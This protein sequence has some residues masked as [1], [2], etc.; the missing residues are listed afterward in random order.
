MN[1]DDTASKEKL[2]NMLPEHLQERLKTDRDFSDKFERI[3]AQ[4]E[5]HEIS[6]DTANRRLKDEI[7]NAD[8][9]VYYLT[10]EIIVVQ[11]IAFK[12]LINLVDDLEAWLARIPPKTDYG[13][14]TYRQAITYFIDARKNVEFKR[15]VMVREKLNDGSLYLTLLLLDQNNKL[16]K[17]GKHIVGR[18]LMLRK[19]DEQLSQSFKEHNVVI[20]E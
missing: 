14:Y 1:K 5:K 18:K 17:K 16:V 10:E 8:D 20:V 7:R 19:L 11:R 2:R 15:G 9:F 4:W 13:V 12:E 3:T 6:T